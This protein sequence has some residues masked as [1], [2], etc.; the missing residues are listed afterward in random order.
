MCRLR[1]GGLPD[2]CQGGR[3][4][5]LWRWKAIML[6]KYFAFIHHEFF[7]FQNFSF[8]EILERCGVVVSMSDTATAR[9]RIP[10]EAP[11][12]CDL[13]LK[14]R[15][16]L[17]QGTSSTLHSAVNWVPENGLYGTCMYMPFRVI[18]VC[19]ALSLQRVRISAPYRYAYYHYC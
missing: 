8:L 14:L 17:G 1:F 11:N 2:C 19:S 13:G 18:I 16:V 6:S 12:I 4:L 15:C 7:P 9:V 10:V 3:I 5:F